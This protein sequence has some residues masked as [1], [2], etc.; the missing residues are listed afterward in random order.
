MTTQLQAIG[1]FTKEDLQTLKETLAVGTTDAQFNL[2]IRTAVASGLNP[3]LNHIFA[4]VYQGKMSLQISVEGITYLAKKVEGYEGIDP[5]VVCENDVFRAYRDKNSE[6]IID[7]HEVTFPRGKIIAAY[8]IAYRNGFKPFTVLIDISE[9]EHF[10]TSSIPAQATMWKKYTADMFKKYVSK[11]AAK[12]QFGIDVSE[13]DAPISSLDQGYE[14]QRRDITQEAQE[15]AQE[16]KHQ[17]PDAEDDIT[18][19]KKARAEMK[20][21]FALLGIT[22][23]AKMQSYITDNSKIDG[24]K[25]TLTELQGL[26]KTMDMHI[27]EKQAAEDDELPLPEE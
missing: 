23:P 9:V 13:D 15:A 27:A 16:R 19:T 1:E 8:A 2:F 7:Q 4:I 24:D 6:W 10:F 5:Q 14:P 21:K 18:K 17:E 22:D 12:G 3:F 11:R 20:K 25:P 26:L